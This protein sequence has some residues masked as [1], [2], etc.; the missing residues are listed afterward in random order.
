LAATAHGEQVV[1]LA[2][3]V[4]SRGSA[5][6]VAWPG[7][8]ANQPGAWRPHGLRLLRLLRPAVPPT[9]AVLGLADRGLGR[10]RLWQPMRQ[11][12]WQPGLQLQ[13]TVRCQ[14]LGERRRRARELG[15]GPGSAWVGRGVAVRARH[16]CCVGTRVVVWAADQSTPW[17][18]L[19]AVPPARVGVCW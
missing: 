4:L 5:I 3:S 9:M 2:V 11:L 17:V 14:P 16:V 12:G 8:P 6:P 15:P 19:T 7:L 13:D 10:P 1:V 18:V